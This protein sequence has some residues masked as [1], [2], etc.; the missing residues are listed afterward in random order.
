MMFD[1]KKFVTLAL[2]ED[3]GKG[4]FTSQAII[5]K[6]H[7][8]E[9]I[10]LV[11]EACIIAGIQI[12]KDI[13]KIVDPD[14][15]I[16]TYYRDGDFCEGN[17]VVVAKVTSNTLTILKVERLV[18]NILQRMSAIATKTNKYVE[19]VKGTKARILDT[20]KTTPLF[21]YFEKLAVR[22][23]GGYNHRFGLYDMI[24]IKDNHIDC[25]GGI[26]NAINKTLSFLKK[27][28]LNIPIEIEAR[29][30]E[31]VKTILKI[32][33]I[34]RIM[35]DNFSIENTKK[36]VELIKNKYE[37]ESSG[38]INLSNVRDYALC[39][40]DYLSVGDLTHNVKSIDMS[41][42]IIT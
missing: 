13:F 24:L 39:G 38:G 28:E 4:D 17:R 33:G 22:I 29:T 2:K 1:L 36:A 7:S 6:K 32:G 15:S 41:L 26:E 30:L 21:R 10:L 37:I 34:N 3:V 9:A 40:V 12:F 16:E 11:K 35:L 8:S 20:R 23:G 31:D 19:S 18:L 27:K 42:K 14:C 25:A 5:D